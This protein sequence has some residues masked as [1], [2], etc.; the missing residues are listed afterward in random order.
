MIFY[1]KLL[2]REQIENCMQCITYYDN[3]EKH[4]LRN[5]EPRVAGQIQI[6]DYKS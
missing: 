2:D 6:I 5:I 3:Y 1:P 4:D